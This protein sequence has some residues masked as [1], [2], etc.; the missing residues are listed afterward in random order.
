[1]RTG[2]NGTE[3]NVK[4]NMTCIFSV[5]CLCYNFLGQSYEECYALVQPYIRILKREIFSKKFQ[6]EFEKYMHSLDAFYTPL[7]TVSKV[8]GKLYGDC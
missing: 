1:M 8:P 5:C 4:Q 6:A 3:V 2:P 7:G